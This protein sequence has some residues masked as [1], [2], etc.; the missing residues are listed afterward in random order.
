MT[1]LRSV[2]PLAVVALILAPGRTDAQSL[3]SAEGLGMPV[4]SLDARSRALGS[5]GV[6]L[7]GWYLLDRDPAASAGL[8]IPSVTASLQSSTTTLA[9]GDTAGHTRFPTLAASY[10]YGRNVFSLQTGSFLDQEWEAQFERTLDFVGGQVGAVDAF[11]STGSI[12]RVSLGWARSLAT[13]LS[14]GVTLGRHTGIVER[15]FTRSIEPEDVGPDVALFETATRLRASGMVVGAGITWDPLPLVRA[16]G[17]FSWSDD[18]VLSPTSTESEEGG[19]YR[20]PVELRGGGTVTLTST[21]ALHLGATY[22]NWS[23]TGDDLRQGMSRDATWSYGGGLEW[24]GGSLVGRTVPLRFGIRH[25]DLP[26]YSTDGPAFER[27]FSGGLGLNLLETEHQPLAR[28]DLG[29]ERGGREAGST[30]EDY[31]QMV[32]TVRVASG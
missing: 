11:I 26:F 14:I 7:S 9:G 12:G 4:E 27:T 18:L 28:L 17:A 16:S 21:L 22:A 5:A 31:W 32:V 6:G 8:T 10:P 3:F 25:R 29:L 2:A 1:W 30:S 19:R 15:T 13:S 23:D 20:I 24:T